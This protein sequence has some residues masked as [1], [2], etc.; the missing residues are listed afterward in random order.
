MRSQGGA[1]EIKSVSQYNKLAHEASK[2]SLNNFLE[3]AV[4]DSRPNP[5]R[6]KDCIQ[7]YQK[8]MFKIL[9]PLFD[10]AAGIKETKKRTAYLTGVKG[11]SKTSAIALCVGWLLQYAKQKVSIIAAA[12]DRSQADILR[13][14]IIAE[15]EHNPFVKLQFNNWKV[16]GDMGTL[17][18]LSSDWHTSSGFIP[19]VIILDELSMMENRN[20][21]DF[22]FAARNKRPCIFIILT[23]AGIKQHF[24]YDIWKAAH[25]QDWLTLDI[26]E[27]PAFQDKEEIEKDRAI[28][29]PKVFRSL[30]RG[31][32]VDITDDSP[33]TKIT[34]AQ[35]DRNLLFQ[36]YGKPNV[37]YTMGVDLGLK[38]DYSCA[39]I[40]H[41]E[42]DITYL[43]AIQYWKGTP[44][45]PVSIEGVEDWITR[46]MS[47]FNIVMI[48]LDNW[49][50]ESTRQKFSRKVEVKD[51]SF[52]GTGHY[53]LAENF[54]TL[55]DANRF[56]MPFHKE[57]IDEIN[58]LYVIVKPNN[59]YIVDH[60]PDRHNDGFVALTLAMF[61]L[62]EVWQRHDG[63]IIKFRPTIV[64][65]RHRY[66]N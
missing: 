33:F 62:Q 23:N 51:Y 65:E 52:G 24:S 34:E 8:D 15:F 16:I 39:T 53:K 43:D 17:D 26:N 20:L 19:E 63:D 46:Q 12:A 5:Q 49:Q 25:E 13:R 55:I 57:L 45:N 2:K 36:T 41:R 22:L 66:V 59:T 60:L 42:G 29:L 38:H 27:T 6:F 54:R 1:L 3:W 56:K 44:A 10:H 28:L 64:P 9:I 31:E 37:K 32:W 4:I 40:V 14:R 48:T 47:V 35:I 18:I 21:F 58:N 30:Y 50:L 11:C 61:G 7:S